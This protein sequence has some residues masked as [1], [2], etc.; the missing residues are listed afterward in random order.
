MYLCRPDVFLHEH[1]EL[2]LKQYQNLNKLKG[3]D[4]IIHNIIKKLCKE[5]IKLKDSKD[6]IYDLFISS[7][8]LHDEGKKNPYFQSYVGNEEE[9]KFGKLNKHHT[10]ISAI[11]YCIEMYNKYIKNIN[12]RLLQE[13]IKDIILSFAYNIYKHHSNLEDFN[14]DKFINNLIQYYEEN[15][16]QFINLDMQNVEYLYRFANRGEVTYQNPYTY[17]LLCKLS[18]SILVSCDFMAV[19]SFNNKEDLSINIINKNIK[20]DI[21]TQFNNNIVIQSI[22]N[23]QE[24]PNLPLSKLNKMRTEMFLESERQLLKYRQDNKIFYLEAPTG[25]GKS[26]TS[27][28]LAYN[29]LDNNINK[30]YYI[31][32]FN[33]IAEQTHKIIQDSFYSDV[34]TVNSREEV[35]ISND[36]EINYD[37]DFLNMQMINY[38]VLLISHVKFFDIFF[39]TNRI[40]NLMLST[41]CNSVIILDEIQS[42]KNSIWINIINTLKEFAEMLNIKI[43]IMSATLPKMDKLL[44]DKTYMI[45]DLIDDRDY[46][47][48]FFKQRVQFDFTLLNKFKNDINDV[49]SKIDN[50]IKNTNKHRILIECLTTK[51][52]DLFYKEMKKYENEG[53]LVFKIIGVTNSLSRQSMITMIQSKRDGKYI[54]DKVI[55]IGTQCIEAGIDIDMQIGF[56]DISILDADEQFAGRIERNFNDIGMIYF[57]DIDDVDFIYKGDFRTERNLKNDE[58]KEVFKDKNFELFYNRNYKWLLEERYDEYISYKNKLQSL[59]Y[60]SVQ[61]DMKLIDSV[62]YT[63]LFMC[64]Y[65]DEKSAQQLFEEYNR[66]RKLNIKYAEK[67][68]KLI[69]IKKE[70]SKYIYSI[71]AYK[72]KNDILLEKRDNFYIVENGYIYFDNLKNKLLTANSTLD[73]ET[74]VNDVG[75]FV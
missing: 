68:I 49:F 50:I 55:L 29:L 25:S 28:N 33:N 3:L 5:N 48:N 19:Y 63:F 17:Y 16:E 6:I 39:S 59:Q 70:L 51:T 42:Y 10:E 35:Y 30:I 23:F 57:F 27:L 72:F 15:Q 11:Y 71:N 12:K 64:E 60:K 69:Q 47:Y 54:Y 24:N 18:Y 31:S 56:K 14:K 74:F 75:L 13:Y 53:F 21:H 66:I 1:I 41:L 32:P 58:W 36:E 2:V 73:I 20:D 62:N 52:A 40:K 61:D 22:R 65:V 46:Y 8:K 37:K 7:L 38:P 44:E 26:L 45:P 9:Y 34:V 43:I 4:I 67:Q